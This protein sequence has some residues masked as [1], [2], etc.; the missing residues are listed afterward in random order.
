ML[1]ILRY[2]GFGRAPKVDV[3]DKKEAACMINCI[4]LIVNLLEPEKFQAC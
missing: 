3:A 1:K 2:Q 4:V